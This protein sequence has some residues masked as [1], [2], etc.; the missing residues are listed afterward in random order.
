MARQNSSSGFSII[1]VLLVLVV[2]G[3]LGFTGWYVYHARQTS[4]K[5]Y[6]VATQS[7][8]PASPYAS[9]KT[10]SLQF[11]RVSYQY[12][13]NWAIT[14]TSHASNLTE[15]CV[16]PGYDNVTLTSPSGHQIQLR[17]GVSCIGDGGAKEYG[18]VSVK[19]LGQNGY[20]VLENTP[21]GLDPDATGP[22]Y[23]C[24]SQTAMA[25]AGVYQTAGAP[26]P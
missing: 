4:D 22:A 21:P 6:T 16:T 9:W 23:A 20:L 11:E 25:A 26:D 3:I 13:S 18:S 15:G 8:V 10:G 5:D 19:S 14:N 2:V 17:T 12:P 7:T 1:E 24:L